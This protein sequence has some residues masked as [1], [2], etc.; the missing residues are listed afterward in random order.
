[1]AGSTSQ[2][3][4]AWK[5]QQQGEEQDE[6]WLVQARKPAGEAVMAVV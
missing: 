3:I 5:Q 6:K 2:L 1:V 4:T